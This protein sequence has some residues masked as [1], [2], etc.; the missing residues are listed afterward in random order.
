MDG[1]FDRDAA[2]FE[3]IGQVSHGVLRLSHG[4]AIA[5]DHHHAPGRVKQ[6]RDFLGRG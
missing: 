5:G 2:L 4:H 6:Q 1:V 3:Q